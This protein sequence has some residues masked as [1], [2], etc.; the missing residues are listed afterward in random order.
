MSQIKSKQRVK[1]L[2]EVYTNEREV[3][4]MLDLV[5]KESYRVESK[6]LEPACGNGNFLVKILERKMKTITDMDVG[7]YVFEF[8]IFMALSSIYGIDICAEN[9]AESKA[10]LFAIIEDAHIDTH[11]KMSDQFA[12]VVNYLLDR[13]IFRADFLNEQ[14]SIVFSQFVH[15]GDF[16][17]V[18]SKYSYHKIVIEDDEPD[19]E[20]LPRYFLDF[21]D[22]MTNQ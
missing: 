22:K 8:N 4:A 9:V 21:V 5:S 18:E 17:I 19:V 11:G 7:R 14:D 3:N 12:S 2:A 16:N 13:N 6:F 10:R 15:I 20:Y 1:D